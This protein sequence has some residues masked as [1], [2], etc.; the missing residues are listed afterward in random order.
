MQ[1]AG[2][3]SW[4][5]EVW[6]DELKREVSAGEVL[7]LEV[8]MSTRR[9]NILAKNRLKD[10]INSGIIGDIWMSSLFMKAL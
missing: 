5:A 1:I 8:L 4:R 3:K 2:Y 7:C 9:C 6:G 10:V